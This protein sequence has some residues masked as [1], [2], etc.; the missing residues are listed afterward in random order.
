MIYYCINT[1]CYWSSCPF[2]FLWKFTIYKNFWSVLVFSNV[3]NFPLVL[4]LLLLI[5]VKKYYYT[6][7]KQV[8]NKAPAFKYLVTKIYV[9]SYQLIIYKDTKFCFMFDLSSRISWKMPYYKDSLK[10]SFRHH[11]KPCSEWRKKKFLF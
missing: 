4:I 8:I 11:L 3:K 9:R 7:S 1:Y 2:N 10:A 5:L 6:H